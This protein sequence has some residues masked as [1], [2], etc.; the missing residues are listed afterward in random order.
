MRIL[1]AIFFFFIKNTL[2][3]FKGPLQKERNQEKMQSAR[4]IHTGFAHSY[5]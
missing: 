1:S 4:D 3:L 5:Y 2:C